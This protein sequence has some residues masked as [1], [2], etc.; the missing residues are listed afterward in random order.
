MLYILS[1]ILG[2]ERLPYFSMAILK[3]LRY[4]IVQRLRENAG[5]LLIAPGLDGGVYA[6]GMT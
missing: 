1:Q 6:I 2:S 4:L 5:K 3:S